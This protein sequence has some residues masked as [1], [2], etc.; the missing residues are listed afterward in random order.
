M[1]R[2][3]TPEGRILFVTTHGQPFFRNYRAYTLDV[4]G[5]LPQLLPLGQVN[6]LAYGPGKAMV[7]GR[8]TA[9]P[10]RWKR[11]RG[12][13]AGHLWIDAEGSGNFRRM[14]RDPRQR[15]EPDVDRRSRVLPVATPKA[16][17]ISTRS[18]RTAATC[19]A[20][21]TTTISTR[22]TRRPT[23]S[24]S[25]TNAARDIYVYDVASGSTRKFDVNVPAHRTQ[26][27]RKFVSAGEYLGEF[28]VHPAGHSVA[29]DVRGKLFTM[30]LW[31]G[32]VRQWGLADGARH[33]HPQWLA[34]G[35]TVV[36]VS[37]ETGEE[38]V[39]TWNGGDHQVAAVGCRPRDRHARG[40]Q[41]HAR[42]GRQPSQR[43]DRRRRRLGR[44]TGHR[45]ERA[46]PHRGRRVVAR[47]QVARVHV[48]D[49][50]A[51]LRDQAL[52]RRRQDRDARHAAGVPR[53]LAGVRSDGQVPLLPVDPHVR[54]G[55]RRGAVRAFVPARVAS[56]RRSRCR[57]GRSRRSIRRPRGSFPIG[58]NRRKP[59]AERRRARHAR[60]P[61]RHRAPRRRRSRSPRTSSGRSR[62]WPTAR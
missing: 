53:L 43:G 11:Y 17:A 58:R 57:R 10:A 3:F 51:P 22:A 24:A 31:E 56:V 5:G 46:R 42:R 47:R 25:C 27:A 7:I 9:D 4:A 2:G 1:V 48:L 61:A 28:N 21:R 36:A 38:R 33:R 6:H 59:D 32:A 40:A 29:L 19:S 26:A 52:Q 41:R 55:V 60:R 37:D 30:G 39:Q 15:D 20:T 45:P 13:T 62:G 14:S 50:R 23:A 34:D 44:G 8:N 18:V 49:R 35:E 54:S 16:W 12:G